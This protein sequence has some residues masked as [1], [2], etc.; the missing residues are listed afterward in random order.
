[1][2]TKKGEARSRGQAARIRLVHWNAAEARERALCLAGLGFIVEAALPDGPALLK[3][4]AASL[5]DAIVI[6]LTRLPSHGR[7]MALAIRQKKATRGIPLVFAAGEPSKVEG[8]RT[9]LPDAVFTPWETIGT[10]IREAIA[11]PP[12]DPV[13]PKSRLEAYVQTPLIKKLGV[14]QDGTVGVIGGRAIL[15]ALLGPLPG[16]AKLEE[17]IGKTCHLALW[18]VRSQKELENEIGS[19]ARRLPSAPLWICWPKK[20]SGAGSDVTEKAVRA[21]GLARGFVD[22]KVCSLDATWSGLLFR[23]RKA[24]PG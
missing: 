6:D 23:R 2:R 5:P 11:H 18:F 8:V 9:L 13:V 16:S 4:I 3:E 15:A 22:Y 21:A 1:V 19:L 10:A 12:G 7:D 24:K 20:A 17:G 14:K